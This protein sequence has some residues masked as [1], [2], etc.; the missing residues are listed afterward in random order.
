MEIAIPTGEYLFLR[1]TIIRANSPSGL[2]LPDSMNTTTWVVVFAGPCATLE[3]G[4]KVIP[5]VKTSVK[6]R[7]GDDVYVV[8]K[9]SEL[10][11]IIV[12]VADA[13][14]LSPG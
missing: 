11:G 13:N 10:L 6:G 12:D 4:T 2:A 1:E 5:S 3:P 8:T 14:N 9:E 7:V